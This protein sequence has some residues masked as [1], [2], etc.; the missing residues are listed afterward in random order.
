MYFKELTQNSPVYIFD[1][2]SMT[3]SQGKVVTRGFP[4]MDVNPTAGISGMVVDLAI[5]VNGKTANYVIPES[6][7]VAYAGNLVLS[8]DKSG[9]A[10]EVQAMKAGAEQHLASV[11]HQKQVLEKSTSLLEELDQTFKER[12]E[13]DKRFSKIEDSVNELKNM[14]NEIMKQSEK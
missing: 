13:A 6:S 9:L 4:R 3:L 14:V 11:E 8:V 5:E 10:T 12:Q 2:Q 7:S 1:K